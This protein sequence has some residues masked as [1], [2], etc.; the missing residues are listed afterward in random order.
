MS[1][2]VGIHAI[3]DVRPLLIGQDRFD[4]LTQLSP[5]QFR[6]RPLFIKQILDL[7]HLVI[8]EIEP[9]GH[10]VQIAFHALLDHVLA[11][12]PLYVSQ[13]GIDL[14]AG[15]D[16]LL[17]APGLFSGHDLANLRL[18]RLGQIEI[19]VHPLD[20]SLDTLSGIR[21]PAI[22]GTGR[23]R[24]DSRERCA[25]DQTGSGDSR[26]PIANAIMIH[27]NVSLD[28]VMDG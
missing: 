25:E 23:R 20:V 14:F 13:H 26:N 8:G 4:A 11:F 21:I 3:P 9:V 12:G 2:V 6:I 22:I 16:T 1:I 19:L 5:C 18:L 17:S 27:E 7:G 15:L 24:V 10:P 28:G